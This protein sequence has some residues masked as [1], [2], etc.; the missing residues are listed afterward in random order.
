MI[1]RVFFNLF[2][3]AVRHGKSVTHITVG[4]EQVRD[5]MVITVEDNGTA[6]PPGEKQKIFDK[7]YGKHTGFGLFLVREILAITGISIN[8]TGTYGKGARFEITVPREAYRTI[9]T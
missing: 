8:E 5:N 1:G 7:G 6:D 4:C 3:N 2:D 9:A